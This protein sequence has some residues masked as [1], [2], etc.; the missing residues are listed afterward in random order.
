M[1]FI[2]LVDNREM[3]NQKY[4]YDLHESYSREIFYLKRQGSKLLQKIKLQETKM[5]LR[6]QQKLK[7]LLRQVNLLTRMVRKLIKISAFIDTYKYFQILKQPLTRHNENFFHEVA[8]NYYEDMLK[9]VVLKLKRIN[10]SAIDRSVD[11]T[12]SL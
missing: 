6:K 3:D 9:D 5:N 11:F 7:P 12:I 2:F 8:S 1:I 10:Q 4:F